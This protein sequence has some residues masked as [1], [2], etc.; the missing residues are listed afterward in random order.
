MTS[1]RP[2]RG[3]AGAARR[4]PEQAHAEV[5][6]EGDLPAGS[7]RAGPPLS[8]DPLAHAP[9]SR[10]VPRPPSPAFLRA[11][12]RCPSRSGSARPNG[13]P[14]GA[15]YLPGSSS[16]PSS[17]SKSSSVRYANC[18]GRKAPLPPDPAPPIRCAASLYREPGDERSTESA[19]V[20][21][22]SMLLSVVGEIGHDNAPAQ[23]TR[24]DSV[25]SATIVWQ[26]SLYL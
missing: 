19:V 7:R 12:G 5:W 1:C 14:L 25:T 10:R 23:R 11:F 3:W 20:G 21:E 4:V 15:L 2:S 22:V 6:P 16:S 8:P 24:L 13:S 9:T 26:A 17:A 18:T